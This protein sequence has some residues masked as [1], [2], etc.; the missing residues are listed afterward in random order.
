MLEIKSK[1]NFCQIEVGQNPLHCKYNIFYQN[2]C[3]NLNNWRRPAT[4]YIPLG[5][6]SIRSK[7]LPFLTQGEK[8]RVI[9]T[10]S[11]ILSATVSLKFICFKTWFYYLS[12]LLNMHVEFKLFFESKIQIMNYILKFKILLKK[13][14]FKIFNLNLI[15]INNFLCF[16]NYSNIH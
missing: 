1:Q 10:T 3:L 2:Y 11:M 8:K 16:Y 6:L 4:A 7:P 5:L 14:T 9:Q 15:R 13:I 12:I